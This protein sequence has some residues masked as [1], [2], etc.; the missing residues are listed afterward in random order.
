MSDRPTFALTRRRFLWLAAIA[1][2]ST[3]LGLRLGCYPDDEWEGH[4]LARWEAHVV[5]AV[6]LALI[7]DEP[8]QWPDQAPTPLEVA[9]HVDRYL[10]GFPRPMLREI[11][12]L[13]AFL[14]QGTLAGC[15]F[16][17]ITRLDP[18]DARQFLERLRDQGGLFSQAFQ[19]IRALIYVGFYQDDRTWPAIGYPGPQFE[20]DAPSTPVTP[21][22]AGPY[23]KWIA[24]P[25][26]LPRGL[27]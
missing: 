19:G 5:A 10:R 6:A 1:G 24:T 3:A 4:H 27:Q 26:E 16:R 22:D 9:A 7:P 8:G 17:R 2:G 25:G 18:T 23:K 21:D 15:K 11:R 12:A 14:E 13:M 20:R